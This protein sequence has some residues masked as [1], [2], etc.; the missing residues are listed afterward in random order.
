MISSEPA[1]LSFLT[2]T[3]GSS[4]IDEDRIRRS[5]AGNKMAQKQSHITTAKKQQETKKERLLADPDLRR[6]YTNI[7]RGSP[8]T[9]EV[10]LRRISHFCETNN[11]TPAKFAKL[12]QKNLRKATD[13][14]EDHI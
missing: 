6:W 8:L 4:L 11:I 1:I 10:R 14:I 12:G 7:A 2:S 9:A 5:D 3:N 13:M